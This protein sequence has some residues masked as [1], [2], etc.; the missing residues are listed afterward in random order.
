MGLNKQK[1]MEMME[2]F[3]KEFLDQQFNGVKE[4]TNSNDPKKMYSAAH[5][6]VGSVRYIGLYKLGM[7]LDKM[8]QTVHA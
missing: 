4:A 3:M 2:K 6:M 5:S 7:I 8:Q 1:T